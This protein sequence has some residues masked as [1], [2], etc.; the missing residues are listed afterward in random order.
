MKNTHFAIIM[1]ALALFGCV[2]RPTKTD[3]GPQYYA[4]NP[5]DTIDNLP[6]QQMLG[7]DSARA[8]Y[9]FDKSIEPIPIEGVDVNNES[10]KQVYIEA[11]TAWYKMLEMCSQKRYEEML[12]YYIK[13]ESIVGIGLSTSTNKFELDYCVLSLLIIDYFD[14]MEAVG[15]LAKWLEYDKLLA[16]GVVAFSLAE[17]GS[18]YIPPQYAFQI[19]MLCKSYS[20]L[21]EREKAEALIEPYG[22][23]VYLLSDDIHENESQIAKFKFDIYDSF[24]DTERALETT[25][26][27]RDFLIQ[28]A[29]DTG[30][31]LD[32]EIEAF[33]EL[34]KELKNEDEYHIDR[35]HS[36]GLLADNWTML[37]YIINDLM[38]C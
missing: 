33:D 32:E 25:I 26:G 29:N 15:L 13:N 17:G 1:A 5:K 27:Y 28:Y 6:F 24:G 22:R 7:I 14:F 31:D 21:D 37:N 2:E 23:A 35:A 16:D 19:E 30:Q 12:S 10:D 36:S 18:G 4:F 20:F 34:I 38:L 9:L 11:E 8:E 3:I